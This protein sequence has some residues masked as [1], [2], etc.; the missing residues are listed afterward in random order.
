MHRL[1]FVVD[2][3]DAGRA[4]LSQLCALGIA[5]HRHAFCP[6]RRTNRGR[7]VPCRV[8]ADRFSRLQR[9]PGYRLVVYRHR[10]AQ[11]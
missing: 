5:L 6:L 9:V 11:Q 10:T 8:V 4:R 3:R 1:W 2:P 7:C